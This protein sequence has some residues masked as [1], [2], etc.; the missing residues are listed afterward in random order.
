[1]SQ[2]DRQH[3]VDVNDDDECFEDVCFLLN[4]TQLSLRRQLTLLSMFL[5]VG[6]L[7]NL[8][9]DFPAN[10]NREDKA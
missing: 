9:Q 3:D 6:S 7:G 2:Y 8:L 1:M 5:T 4:I 10:S